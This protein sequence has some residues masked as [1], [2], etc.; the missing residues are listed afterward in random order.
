M[1]AIA[2]RI[3]MV[4]EHSPSTKALVTRL[5][6]RR[7]GARYVATRRE[8]EEVLGTFQFDVVLAVE[9]L[10]DG[11]GYDLANMLDHRLETL[12]VS[13][14]LSETCLWLPVIE[15]GE[16]VL[17][18]RAL[19]ATM[20]EVG[21]EMLLSAREREREED[22]K[23]ISDRAAGGSEIGWSRHPKQALS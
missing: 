9:D 15:R 6:T 17:G 2:I 8:A 16:R 22:P 20:A 12:M 10:R 1:S 21:L 4:G 18:Q 5:A 14:A 13:V 23:R 3:L 19:N 7:W 11:R